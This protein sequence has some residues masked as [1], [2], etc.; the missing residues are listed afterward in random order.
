MYIVIAVI[1]GNVFRMGLQWIFG[2][3]LSL[4][5]TFVWLVAFVYFGLSKFAPAFPFALFKGTSYTAAT[6]AVLG[7]IV[8]PFIVAKMVIQETTR[9]SAKAWVGGFIFGFMSL[10]IVLVWMIVSSF[11]LGKANENSSISGENIIQAFSML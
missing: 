11:D 6:F 2:K 4:F 10:S 9:S 1:I 7:V 5:W 3:G 8:A